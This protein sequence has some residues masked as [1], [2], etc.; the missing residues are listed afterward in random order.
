MSHDKQQGLELLIERLVDLAVTSEQRARAGRLN[1]PRVAD[2]PSRRRVS[3]LPAHGLVAELPLSRLRK[4]N[5]LKPCQKSLKP[6]S[7]RRGGCAREL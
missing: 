5:I 7:C 2:S 6:G 1:F 4:L 3:Q